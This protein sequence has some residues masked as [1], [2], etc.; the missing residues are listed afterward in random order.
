MVITGKNNTPLTS[1]SVVGEGKVEYV[2]NSKST[3]EIISETKIQPLYTAVRYK[4]DGSFEI[5]G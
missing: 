5:V 3:L 2:S 4:M 1:V